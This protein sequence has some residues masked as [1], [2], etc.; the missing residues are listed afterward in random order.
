MVTHN[1]CLSG[2]SACARYKIKKTKLKKRGNFMHILLTKASLAGGLLAPAAAA[3]AVV[4]VVVVVV[5][6]VPVVNVRGGLPAASPPP[7]LDGVKKSLVWVISATFWHV[8][9]G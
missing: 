1:V 4:V 2:N 3:A 7:L 5:V 8:R 6:S 9:I